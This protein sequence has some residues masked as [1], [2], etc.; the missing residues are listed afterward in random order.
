MKMV[1][2]AGDLAGVVAIVI[3]AVLLVAVQS[4]PQEPRAKPGQ[5]QSVPLIRS[6][7]GADLFHAYC[8][9]C[10]GAD[11]K[12]KGPVAAALNTNVPDLTAISKRHGGVFPARWIERVI[13]GDEA[14]LAHGSRE[15][16]I[17]GPIF[18]Q[19]EEDRD[20]GNIR[21]HNLA[22]YLESIQQK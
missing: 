21:M 1:K 22:K 3:C 2:K 15:M 18:H 14:M 9:S 10:H 6:L 12:G 5:N 11:A 16:P 19:V 8:A 7:D 13:A 17:W 4:S 20:F